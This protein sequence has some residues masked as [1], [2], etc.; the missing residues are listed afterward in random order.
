V[1]LTDDDRELMELQRSLSASGAT[2][3]GLPSG[4]A[5]AADPE[6]LRTWELRLQAQREAYGQYIA[7]GDIWIGNCL[8]FTSGQPVPLEHVIRYDL[9]EREQVNRVAT[10]EMARRGRTFEKDEEFLAANPHIARQARTLTQT[11]DLHPSALDPRG[12]GAAKDEA[13][14][15]GGAPA[16]TV[17]GDLSE[18]RQAVVTEAAEQLAEARDDD[19]QDD[20]KGPGSKP[21]RKTASAGKDE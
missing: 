10:P 9:I 15:R 11:G 3:A 5:I 1:A 2:V 20:G 16:P 6:A 14:K 8:T 18:D 21:R 12:G 13:R 17:A 19:G 4:A 7:N